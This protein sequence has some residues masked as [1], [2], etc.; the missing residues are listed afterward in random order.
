M[1]PEGVIEHA[2]ALV[3]DGL[4]G[5][6]V[7]V[8]GGVQA[9]GAVPML[10]VLPKAKDLA[11]LPCCLDRGEVAREAGPVFLGLELGVADG[12]VVGDVE[13]AVR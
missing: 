11:L 8:G 10:I 2:G 9:Q 7:D 13:A 3:A 5:A 6:V 1:R 4:G 12:A